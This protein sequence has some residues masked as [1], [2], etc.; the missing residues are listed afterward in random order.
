MG[1]IAHVAALVFAL[2]IGSA[3]LAADPA[4]IAFWSSVSNSSDP[5]E[6]R[7]YLHA[8]PHG[9]FV[10]IAKLKLQELGSATPAAAPAQPVHSTAAPVASIEPTRGTWRAIDRIELDVDASNLG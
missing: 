4:D 3:A 1:R 2:V 9:Q 10:E 6:L 7:A 5:A 8:F